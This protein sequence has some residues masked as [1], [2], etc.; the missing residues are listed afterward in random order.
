[1]K[2]ILIA[3]LAI[4][5]LSGCSTVNS[6]FVAKYDTNEYELINWIR[7]SAELS[8]ET[9]DNTYLSKENYVALYRSSIEF[10]N[11]TQYLRRNQ[12][13][14]ALATNLHQLIDQGVE[15]YANDNE[16]SQTFCE[17]SLSQIIESAETIQ[18]VLGDK[19]R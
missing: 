18:K 4:M 2:N 15:M 13:T 8:V 3:A 6:L 11:F 5:L 12:D 14:Y 19:P 7:T 9:C 16:V 17:L 1:M 10:K